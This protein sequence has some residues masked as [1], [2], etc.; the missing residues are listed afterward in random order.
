MSNDTTIRKIPMPFRERYAELIEIIDEFCAAHLNDEYK[1]VSQRLAADLCQ[2][3]SPILKGKASSWAAGI[4]W[5]IGRVNFLSDMSFEPAMTQQEFSKAIGVSPATISAKSRVI[6]NGLQLSPLDPD[7]T[8]ASRLDSNPMVWMAEVDGLIMDLS[9]AP[10]EIQEAAYE[11]GLI[12]YIP[13]DRKCADQ[14]P[15]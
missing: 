2:D 1:E 4:L 8:V 7:Y 13:A 10:R 14:E 3:G 6:W 9:S 11:Q 15:A 12:P 5:S